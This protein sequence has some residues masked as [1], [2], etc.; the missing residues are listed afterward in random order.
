MA[1]NRDYG[2]SI[3]LVDPDDLGAIQ[4]I[5]RSLTIR[6][7]LYLFTTT[8]IFRVLTADT[9]DPDRKHPETKPSYEKIYSIG[10][11]KPMVART[12]VQF[13]DIFKFLNSPPKQEKLIDRLWTCTKHLLD[14]EKASFYIYDQ[15]MKLMPV[16]DKIIEDNK[17]F[18]NIPALPKISDLDTYVWHFL[19]SSKHMLAETFGFLHDFFGMPFN[20][21][22]CA[23]FDKHIDWITKKFGEAHLLSK[24][25]HTDKNWIQII[26]E[27]SNTNGG[28]L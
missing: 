1:F 3:K 27:C 7:D 16:C 24:M 17:V 5:T 6:D 28:E 25:L 12:I 15:T 20:A 11:Q 21:Q 19:M 22:N 26:S 18:G 4:N 2:G 13:N 23:H 14:C 9:L 10:S 8:A